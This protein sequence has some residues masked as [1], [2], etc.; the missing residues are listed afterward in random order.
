M[1]H[2]I[3]NPMGYFFEVLGDVPLVPE[4]LKAAGC[5]V[6][7]NR[8]I[9]YESICTTTGLDLDEVGGMELVIRYDHQGRLICVEA[10]GPIDYI[11]DSNEYQRGGLLEYIVEWEL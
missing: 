10:R 5:E 11:E 7:P 1:N 2:Y 6:C 9:M 4:H 3:I 8:H